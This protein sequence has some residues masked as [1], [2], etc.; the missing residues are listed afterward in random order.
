MPTAE[1][2]PEG[3]CTQC[4]VAIPTFHG[5]TCCP[6][7]GSTGKPC[8]YEN[9]VQV[10]INWHELRLLCIWAE[11]WACQHGEKDPSMPATV[12]AIAGRLQEQHENM[13]AQAPLTLN[14]EF[15]RLKDA[16]FRV[17]TN[18]PEARGESEPLTPPDSPQ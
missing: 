1:S 14:G 15:A 7:C 17:R 2:K 11:R 16:G 8:G 18:M 12:Y 6:N 3:F 9:Q 4:G 5:L 13:T 10:S